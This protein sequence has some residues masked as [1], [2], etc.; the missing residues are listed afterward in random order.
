MIGLYDILFSTFRNLN[1][2][3]FSPNLSQPDLS[4]VLF[5]FYKTKRLGALR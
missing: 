4:G 1:F 3:I 5:V 2:D